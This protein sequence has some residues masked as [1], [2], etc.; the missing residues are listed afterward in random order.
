M[1][2]YA[3]EEK[4]IGAATSDVHLDYLT[5][6]REGGLDSLSLADAANFEQTGSVLLCFIF[7]AGSS[8]FVHAWR[9]IDLIAYEGRY[10]V[11]VATADSYAADKAGLAV[12]EIDGH[13]V[14]AK[15]AVTDI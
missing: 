15:Y 13:T 3:I 14:V 6:S 5:I 4:I 7:A 11:A 8:A 9:A 1:L 12:A 2:A 10:L